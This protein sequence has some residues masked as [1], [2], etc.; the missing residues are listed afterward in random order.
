MIFTALT[1]AI[2][3]AVVSVIG[4][5]VGAMPV[6]IAVAIGFYLGREVAQHE[7]KEPGANLLRGLY[8]WRWS[9]DAKL[10]LLLPVIACVIVYVALTSF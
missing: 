5:L 3:A 8:L 9:T 1:H 7:R 6:G 2:I 10:D 4:W